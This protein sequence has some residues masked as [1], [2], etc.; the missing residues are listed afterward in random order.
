M[1]KELITLNELEEM[2]IGKRT[3]IYQLIR[4]GK[5][6]KPLKYG[7][8]NRWLLGDVR[9][10]IHQQNQIAQQGING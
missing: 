10:W 7:R 8:H 1:L 4:E 5:F 9:E 2:G 6:P 3:K